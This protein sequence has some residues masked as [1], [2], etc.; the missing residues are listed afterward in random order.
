[1]HPPPRILPHVAASFERQG[2]MRSLGARLVEAV[3]GRCT[4]EAPYSDAIGQQH[5]LFHGGAVAALADTAGGYAALS[6]APGREVLTAE[7]KISFLRPAA[8]PL[9]RVRAETLRVGRTLTTVACRVHMLQDGAEVHCAEL[10]GTM[11]IRNEDVQ[12]D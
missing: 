1:M 4:I 12:P 9:V 5:G 7:F 11:A 2:L 6:A 8:G 10:I 3:D